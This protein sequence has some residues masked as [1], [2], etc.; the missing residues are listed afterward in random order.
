MQLE[1]IKLDTN[2]LDTWSVL[3]ARRTLLH[4]SEKESL[5]MQI[6]IENAGI[7]HTNTT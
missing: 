3:F 2:H 7:R 1:S 5:L 4:P 6:Q